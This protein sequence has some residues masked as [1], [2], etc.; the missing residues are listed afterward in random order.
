MLCLTTSDTCVLIRSIFSNSGSLNKP[1]YCNEFIRAI[2]FSVL[3]IKSRLFQNSLYFLYTLKSVI[4]VSEFINKLCV[5]FPD[6]EFRENFCSSELN[7]H[8]Y[9][10]G[11]KCYRKVI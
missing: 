7:F 11:C 9:A 4:Y 8:L 10:A 5:T 3:Y 1:T 2:F 6:H